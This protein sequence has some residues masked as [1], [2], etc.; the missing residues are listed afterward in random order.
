MIKLA[1]DGYHVLLCYSRIWMNRPG[2]VMAATLLGVSTY[3]D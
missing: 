1:L 2:L 3:Y